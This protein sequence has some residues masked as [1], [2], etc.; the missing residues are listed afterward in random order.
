[1]RAK[2]FYEIF[3]LFEQKFLL[4]HNIVV[5]LRILLTLRIWQIAIWLREVV[6]SANICSR[7]SCH[8]SNT[9]YSELFHR[10]TAFFDKSIK[11]GSSLFLRKCCPTVY[12]FCMSPALLNPFTGEFSMI[13]GGGIDHHSKLLSQNLERTLLIFK[14][15]TFSKKMTK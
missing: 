11:V 5:L 10:V 13:F 2:V 15:W 12:S 4:L 7:S 3:N 6:V 1:V 14:I 9:F 8:R